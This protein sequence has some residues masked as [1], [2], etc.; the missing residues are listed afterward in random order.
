MYSLL[1]KEL[2]VAKHAKKKHEKPSTSQDKMFNSGCN[3]TEKLECIIGPVT[4]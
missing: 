4:L 1:S 2:R 3:H